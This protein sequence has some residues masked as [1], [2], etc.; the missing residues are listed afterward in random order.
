M[1][2]PVYERG[3]RPDLLFC[4][5]SHVSAADL[6]DYKANQGHIMPESR[7]YGRM[8]RVLAGK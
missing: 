3:H 1:K 4:G 8:N 5:Q 6:L 2:H 7:L